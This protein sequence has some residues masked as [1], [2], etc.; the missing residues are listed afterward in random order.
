MLQRLRYEYLLILIAL[1]WVPLFSLALQLWPGLSETGDDPTYLYAARLLYAEGFPDN[2]RPILIAA[3]QGLPYLFGAGNSTVIAWGIALNFCS[4]L[5]TALLLFRIMEPI[6]GRK[7]GFVVAVLFFLLSGNLANAFRFVPEPLF[8][9]SLV[10]AIWQANCYHITL[11]VKHIACAIALLLIVALIKPVALGL[12]VLFIVWFVRQIRQLIFTRYIILPA[13]AFVVITLHGLWMKQTYGDFT[14]SYIGGITYYNYL[15]DKAYSLKEG[16]E[17][18]PGEDARTKHMTTLSSHEVRK[19]AE[20]DFYN[21]LRNNTVNLARAYAFC[22]WSNSHK[23]SFIISSCS[24]EHNTPY[25]PAAQFFFKAVSKLQN[26][27]LTSIGVGLSFYCIARFRKEEKV[28]VLMSFTVL[29][30]F[31]ISGISCMQ[32]DRFHIVFFPLVLLMLCIKFL[33]PKT[34]LRHSGSGVS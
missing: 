1:V 12:A 24:N 28:M 8:I 19:L 27:L 16:K 30:I 5:L 2:T 29:Y 21:Q 10:T 9:I 34:G 11:N 3:L 22:L 18:V 33:P 20:Q 17:Y 25:F 15:G 26:L 4:W 23:G 31:F 13:A 32:S 6:R 7:A 14:L